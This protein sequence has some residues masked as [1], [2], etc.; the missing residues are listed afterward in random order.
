MLRNAAYEGMEHLCILAKEWGAL[1]FNGML[2]LAKSGKHENICRLARE[3]GATDS[4][5][6]YI[7]IHYR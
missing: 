1:D 5:T 4:Y 3:W 7:S 2:S 6:K